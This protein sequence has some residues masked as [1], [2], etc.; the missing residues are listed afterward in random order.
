VL[1]SITLRN[2]FY[3]IFSVRS[4]RFYIFIF[5]NLIE[6]LLEINS[7]SRW[8]ISAI[9]ESKFILI[10][11][12]FIVL[13]GNLSVNRII[14]K[15]RNSMGRSYININRRKIRII[16]IDPYLIIIVIELRKTRT[17]KNFK[18]FSNKDFSLFS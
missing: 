3:C 5:S 2:N 1:D 11:D 7:F 9:S 13:N 12:L 15:T 6:I 10:D 16:K 8:S 17:F 4:I 18:K 14:I